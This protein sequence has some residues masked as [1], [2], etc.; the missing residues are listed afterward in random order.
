VDAV[1]VS[2]AA[3]R[4]ATNSNQW[5]VSISRGRKRVVVFTSDKDELRAGI[6]RLGDRELALDLKAEIF[7]AIQTPDSDSMLQ[8]S[9]NA[10]RSRLHHSM[11]N[12][13]RPQGHRQHLSA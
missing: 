3:S 4:S 5:Y 13:T 6:A 9:I 8:A 12:R 10:E 2:D 11:L 7:S 1:I